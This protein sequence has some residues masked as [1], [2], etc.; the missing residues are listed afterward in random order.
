[1]MQIIMDDTQGK[2]VYLV[3]DEL[4]DKER[5]DDEKQDELMVN[6]QHHE[7]RYVSLMRRI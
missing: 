7:N 5:E 3:K 4:S 2:G 1:M 6:S